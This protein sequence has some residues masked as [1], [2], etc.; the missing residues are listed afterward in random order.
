MKRSRIK[1]RSDK[2]I[3]DDEIRRRLRLAFLAKHRT[4]EMCQSRPPTDVDEIIGRG[5]LPG[6]Q[7]LDHLFQALCRT[8]HRLKTD[9][10]DWAY[11]HGWS[12]HSWDVDR[13]EEILARRARCDLS[14]SIDH[15]NI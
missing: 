3:E 14:C 1:Q 6:A 7:L 13:V 12:A 5:V 15:V 4:C 9:H 10:P 8:C 2:R 11:R